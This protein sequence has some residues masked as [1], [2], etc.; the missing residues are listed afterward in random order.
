VRH[1]DPGPD[2]PASPGTSHHPDH[3]VELTDDRIE[4]RVR[5]GGGAGGSFGRWGG[6]G[7]HRVNN[8]AIDNHHVKDNGWDDVHHL[9]EL[10]GCGSR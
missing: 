7:S 2:H 5:V 3:L 4:Q 8:V 1:A 9:E 6:N 10:S